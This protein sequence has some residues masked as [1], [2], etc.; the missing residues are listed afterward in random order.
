MGGKGPLCE[1]EEDSECLDRHDGSRY[2]RKMDGPAGGEIEMM[3]EL[4]GGVPQTPEVGR[5]RGREREEENECTVPCPVRV[6]CGKGNS[7]TSQKAFAVGQG[8]V[9]L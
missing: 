2:I 3:G 1:E 6:Q 4:R 5:S 9:L 7:S 8:P